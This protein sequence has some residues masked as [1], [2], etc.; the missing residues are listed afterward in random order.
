MKKLLALCLFLIP[1]FS[2][3]KNHFV[4]PDFLKAGDTVAIISP[5]SCPDSIV[6]DSGV[7]VLK[8]WGF[9]PLVGK[10]ALANYRTYAGTIEQRKED[11]LWALCN[12][13]I[14]AIICSRGGQG[15]AQLLCEIPLNTFAKY[16]KWIVGFSDITALLSAEV[17]AG[18]MSIHANLCESFGLLPAQDSANEVLH[19]LLLGQ[20]P[21]YIIPANPYNVQGKATGTLV[22]G[23]MSVYDGLAASDYDFL[24]TKNIILFIEDTEEGFYSVDRMLHLLILRGVLPRVKGLI[25]GR[26]TGYKP[27]MGYTDMYQMIHEQ[28]SRYHF[29]FPICYGFPAGHGSKLANFPL[30]EGCPVTLDVADKG[31]EVTFSNR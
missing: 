29:N 24:K 1:I 23:N 11:L 17:S 14:K 2:F 20:L 26:F 16:P 27:D 15:A 8:K 7:A 25:I 21:H 31:V 12:P 19:K 6:I 18:N 30:V 3:G 10:N 5:S 13:S 4:R 9:V 28:L 22:G